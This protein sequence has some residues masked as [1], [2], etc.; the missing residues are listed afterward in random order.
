VYYS[1]TVEYLIVL[2]LFTAKYPSTVGYRDF[3]IVYLGFG[4]LLYG[5]PACFCLL[6][7]SFH[8]P[9]TTSNNKQSTHLHTTYIQSNPSYPTHNLTIYTRDSVIVYA[10]DSLLIEKNL[11]L[12]SKAHQSGFTSSK[13]IGLKLITHISASW[14]SIMTTHMPMAAARQPFAPLD[15]SRLQNLTS[16]KNRQN[17]MQSSTL[18]ITLPL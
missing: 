4:R 12:N 1:L 17:G 3:L 5:G 6:S 11:K 8:R 10:I 9:D 16:I 2:I 18:S 15:G 7:L 13:F 14:I